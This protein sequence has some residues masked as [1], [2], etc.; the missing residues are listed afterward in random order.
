MQSEAMHPI[1]GDLW[2]PGR[3]MSFFVAAVLCVAR[4]A[5]ERIAAWQAWLMV[6]DDHAPAFKPGA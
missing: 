1:S 2:M 5:G 4:K 6:E 3:E